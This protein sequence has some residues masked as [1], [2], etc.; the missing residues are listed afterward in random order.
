M[1]SEYIQWTNIYKC[2]ICEMEKYHHSEV[3]WTCIWTMVS[4]CF[5]NVFL[6]FLQRGWYQL[7]FTFWGLKN[8]DGSTARQ[9]RRRQRPILWADTS[10]IQANIPICVK[11]KT[12]VSQTYWGMIIN[13]IIGRYRE[14]RSYR[15]YREWNTHYKD[16]HYGMDDHKECTLLWP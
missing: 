3:D 7:T 12:W 6:W 2:I 4:I 9:D 16:S 1:Y 10:W 13:Q 5:S 15:A 11:V 14:L 8:S